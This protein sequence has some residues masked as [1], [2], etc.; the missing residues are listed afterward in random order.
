MIRLYTNDEFTHVS[1]ALDRELNE[2]YSFGRLNPY[3]AFWGG[4]VHEHKDR[5]TFKRFSKTRSKIYA[6]CVTQEQYLKIQSTIRRIEADRKEYKFNI[7]GL[8]AAGI[9]KKLG[10]EKSFYCAEFVKYVIE[11]AGIDL[12]LPLIVKPE[13][14]N[15]LPELHEIYN[16]LLRTYDCARDDERELETV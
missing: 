1:I 14:F 12:G 2:M 3:I 11:E 9:H 4:F 10:D 7:L 8:C 16:G 5:G 6:L 15:N 13:D